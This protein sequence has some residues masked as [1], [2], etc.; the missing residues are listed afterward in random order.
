MADSA[1]ARSA[2]AEIIAD[3]TWAFP[4]YEPEQLQALKAAVD[5]FFVAAAPL[6]EV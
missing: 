2:E 6:A 5:Q 4:L 1:A 3:R